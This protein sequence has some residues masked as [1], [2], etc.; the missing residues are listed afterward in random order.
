VS[1]ALALEALSS[2]LCLIG[3]VPTTLEGD[4]G[5]VFG[6]E[7]L[8]GTLDHPW[9][10]AWKGWITVGLEGNDIH[11]AP[12]LPPGVTARSG[13]CTFG[14][15]AAAMMTASSSLEVYARPCTQ[16]RFG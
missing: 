12:A 7:G 4:T 11:E 3:E 6:L 15:A 5:M 9:A 14:E 2:T 1:P 13:L 16:C 8:D 10:L